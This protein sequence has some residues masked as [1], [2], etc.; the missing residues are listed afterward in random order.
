MGQGQK[1]DAVSRNTSWVNHGRRQKAAGDANGLSTGKILDIGRKVK[2]G[3][4]NG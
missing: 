2:A 4:G 1:Q 3:A